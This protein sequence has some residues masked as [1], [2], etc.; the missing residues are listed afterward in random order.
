MER[1]TPTRVSTKR[2]KN[3]LKKCFYSEKVLSQE[4][5]TCSFEVV[6]VDYLY[7]CEGLQVLWSYAATCID[8]A[9]HFLR[10][11]HDVTSKMQQAEILKFSIILKIMFFPDDIVDQVCSHPKSANLVWFWENRLVLQTL[12][13]Y[14]LNF[15]IAK[16]RNAHIEVHFGVWMREL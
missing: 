10:S 8:V 6:V 9:G 4:K 12:S 3:W 16:D 5:I 7:A 15:T 1:E 14:E 13:N 2:Q 11:S